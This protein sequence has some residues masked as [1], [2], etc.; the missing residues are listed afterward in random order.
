[1]RQKPWFPR[2]WRNLA[3]RAFPVPPTLEALDGD[4]ALGGNFGG[5]GVQ[6]KKSA[7]FS[8]CDT[9]FVADLFAA[10]ADLCE[11][12]LLVLCFSDRV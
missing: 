1:L 6:R 2:F 5:G 11:N 9:V 12:S 4:A 7:A 10:L 3:L 8:A